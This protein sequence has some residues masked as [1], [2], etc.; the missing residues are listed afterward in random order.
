[1]D[2]FNN[3]DVQN[4][5]FFIIHPNIAVIYR[6]K[7]DLRSSVCILYATLGIGASIFFLNILKAKLV[8]FF[9]KRQHNAFKLKLQFFNL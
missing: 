9:F 1:M 7:S 8:F 2:T 5:T 4:R 6:V 3:S